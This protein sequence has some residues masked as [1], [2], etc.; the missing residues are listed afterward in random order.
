[1]PGRACTC[2]NGGVG[3]RW[4][5]HQRPVRRC[6]LR[7]LRKPVRGRPVVLPRQCA[8]RTAKLCNGQCID[9]VS[10]QNNCGGAATSARRARTASV[11]AVS[12]RAGRARSASTTSASRRTARPADTDATASASTRR[13][14]R[15]N[16][17]A[18]GNV[19]PNSS[20]CEG[21][22]CS[23]C[24]HAHRLPV[25][26]VPRRPRRD[27]RSLLPPGGAPVLLHRTWSAA[28][29]RITKHAVTDTVAP[30]ERTAAPTAATDPCIPD[31][32]HV[33]IER[34]GVPEIAMTTLA[35]HPDMRSVLIDQRSRVAVM[36]VS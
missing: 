23:P 26:L 30:W 33:R 3:L 35:A 22:T 7:R 12:R 18:C 2:P 36:G 24:P 29:A 9:G 10:D 28:A 19:Y 21:G 15:T 25:R 13:T 20:T 14:I 31:G 34:T 16:A 6:E 1:M 5:V 8:V 11:P 17:A 32:Q 27:T 4:R